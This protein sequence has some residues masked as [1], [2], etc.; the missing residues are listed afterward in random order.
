[1]SETQ[2]YNTVRTVLKCLWEGYKCEQTAFW[3]VAPDSLA[4]IDRRF[5]GTY[6][7]RYQSGSRHRAKLKSRLL[8]L[9]MEAVLRYVCRFKKNFNLVTEEAVTYFKSSASVYETAR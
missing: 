1:M 2:G 5:G 3:D 8:N 9:V 6:Y 7:V 4:D